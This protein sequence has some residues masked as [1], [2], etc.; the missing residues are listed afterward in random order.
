[1]SYIED[2]FYNLWRV[3]VMESIMPAVPLDAGAFPAYIEVDISGDEFEVPTP[4]VNY[5]CQA[6]MVDYNKLVFN[7]VNGADPMGRRTLHKKT[8]STIL[9][10]FNDVSH[11]GMRM[12]H[13]VT[14]KN[15]HY[16]GCN[17]MIFNADYEPLMISTVKVRCSPGDGYVRLSDPRFII[18]YKVF[19]GTP[20][21]VERTLIKQAIPFY[22]S[23]TVPL[24]CS[25]SLRVSQDVVK[26]SVEHSES[27]VIKPVAPRVSDASA[28]RFNTVITDSDYYVFG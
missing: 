10:Q 28:E 26:V 22:S 14:S 20:D 4:L 7:L 12:A 2:F 13:I 21:I 8:V 27:M 16:Y 23:H 6:K 1:M 5:A 18:S 19:E 17:G 3:P 9:K 11:N 15:T 24:I 25:K